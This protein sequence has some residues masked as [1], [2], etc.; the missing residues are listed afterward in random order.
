MNHYLSCC[1]T[2]RTITTSELYFV[3]LLHVQWK[4][5]SRTF[6]YFLIFGCISIHRESSLKI[7][8][9]YVNEGCTECQKTSKSSEKHL[10]IF[11]KGWIGHFFPHGVASG[12]TSWLSA[13]LRITRRAEKAFTGTR[14]KDR[15]HVSHLHE[16]IF[17]KGT[18]SLF[19][20]SSVNIASVYKHGFK[21]LDDLWE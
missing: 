3:V 10:L 1:W 17:F 14:H 15:T 20:C 11:S 12:I 13:L 18:F 5:S 9:E 7:N 19:W 21:I 8:S 16:E 2:G 4:E 6:H